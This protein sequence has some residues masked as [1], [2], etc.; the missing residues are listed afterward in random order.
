MQHTFVWQSQAQVIAQHNIRSEE[1]RTSVKRLYNVALV[2]CNV[3]NIVEN[4]KTP[5]TFTSA[6]LV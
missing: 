4:S 2:D 6:N 3:Q 1:L 5:D